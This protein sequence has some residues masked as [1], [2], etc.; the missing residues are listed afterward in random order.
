[1]VVQREQLMIRTQIMNNH[2]AHTPSQRRRPSRYSST[3]T[4]F[5]SGYS[6]VASTPTE[7]SN[8]SMNASA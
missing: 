4:N 8:V 3:V 7:A 2:T 1:M 5:T 6:S